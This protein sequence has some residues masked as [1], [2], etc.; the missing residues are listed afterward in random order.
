MNNLDVSEDDVLENFMWMSLGTKGGITL[1][2][3]WT[4]PMDRYL[5]TIKKFNKFRKDAY[6][7]K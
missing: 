6:G 3:L 2:T 7:G 5:M 4:M 1:E